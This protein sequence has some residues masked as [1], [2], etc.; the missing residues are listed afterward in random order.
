MRWNP[1]DLPSPGRAR[2]GLIGLLL[3]IAGGFAGYVIYLRIAG[4]HWAAAARHCLTLAGTDEQVMKDPAR[5]E[6]YVRCMAAVDRPEALAI[7]TGGLAVL[8]AGLILMLVLP[9]R[10]LRRA[11][12]LQPAESPWPQRVAALARESGLRRTPTMVFG[13]WRLAEPFTTRTLGGTRIVLPVGFKRLP[14][15]QADAVL[16]HELAHLAGGDVT[17]VWLV[18]GLWWAVPPALLAPLLVIYGRPIM[19]DID[20]PGEV[21]AATVGQMFFWNYLLRAAL[22]LTVAA[23]VSLAVLRSREH[24]ADLRAAGDGTGLRDLLGNGNGRLGDGNGNGRRIGRWQRIRAVHPPAARRLAVL[25]EPAT[26]MGLRLP[27]AAAA[28]VLTAMVMPA[29][30]S[31]LPPNL[32]GSGFWGNTA[33]VTGA[34]A[35]GLLAAVW[36]VAI[37]R[38]AVVARRL[39]RPLRTRA[40]TLGLVAGVPVGLLSQI[41]GLPAGSGPLDNAF[42]LI[43]VPPAVGGAA[44]LSAI[45]ARLWAARRPE[46]PIGRRAWL[47]IG[48]CN[49]VVFTGAIW[50][51]FDSSILARVEVQLGQTDLAAAWVHGFARSGLFNGY[52]RYAAVVV[53]GIAACV[54]WWT[55]P[56]EWLTP[57]FAGVAALAVRWLTEQPHEQVSFGLQRDLWTAVAAG[58]AVVLIMVI[59]RGAAGMPR[60]LVLAP[61]ATMLVAVAI[62]LRY[63]PEWHHP[64]R[65]LLLYAGGSLALLAVFYLPVSLVAAFLPAWRVRLRGGVWT[66]PALAFLLAAGL[67]AGVADTQMVLVT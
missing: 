52:E 28:G 10:L 51:A 40:A 24:E 19:A 1:I 31:T 9:H 22:L 12:P 37:W 65:A 60:A 20:A 49:A 4:R 54:G 3:V 64:L 55:R 6:A 29:L 18:R 62:W 33:H 26:I 35:G 57:V 58:A 43:A 27:D 5:D 2:Y 14:P 32:L 17:L 15:A 42:V 56:R 46:R 25:D 59:W 16:R 13:G 45:L 61:P 8:A 39:E 11:G 7:L 44:A 67:I 53:A 50:A 48:A 23:M 36:G 63:L 34:V 47:V 21:L 66:Q 41:W 38:A 30:Q